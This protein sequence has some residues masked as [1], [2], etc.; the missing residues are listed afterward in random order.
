MVKIIH[1]TSKQ[2]IECVANLA[3]II[4]H[5]HYPSI[6]SLEQIEYMLDLYNS[7]EAIETQIEEGVLF[8]H[9]T[10]FKEPIGYLAVKKED[11]FMFIRKLYILKDHRG[12]GVARITMNFVENLAFSHNLNRLRLY[13]NKYN[14]ISMLAYEQMGFVK[15]NSLVTEIGEGFVMDDYEMEKVLK[16]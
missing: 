3:R 11:G 16:S 15:I 2:E 6:I 8:F 12:K 4:W 5:E 1:A 10:L 9:I 13:V 7:V 14:A